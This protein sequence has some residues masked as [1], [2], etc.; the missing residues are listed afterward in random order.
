MANRARKI[1][2]QPAVI[3]GYDAG[4]R[5]IIPIADLTRRQ[6]SIVCPF[7]GAVHWHG[8]GGLD[9]HDYGSRL[10]HCHNGNAHEY[11]AAPP[12]PELLEAAARLRAGRE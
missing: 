4:G 9:G 3:L 6:F 1:K 11:A 7:C 2:R 10:S 8:R 5:P 12:S